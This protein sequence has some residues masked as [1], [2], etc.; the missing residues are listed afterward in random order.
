M[1]FLH[2]NLQIIFIAKV[3]SMMKNKIKREYLKT[4][5]AL[6]SISARKDRK[7]VIQCRTIGLYGQSPQINYK[8][9]VLFHALWIYSYSGIY[10]E[11]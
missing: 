9:N 7:N 6:S 4:L 3:F 11:E 1:I 10:E 8:S 5:C 2:L